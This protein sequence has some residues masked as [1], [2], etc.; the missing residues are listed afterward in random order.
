MTEE[1]GGANVDR[2]RVLV[3]DDEPM[4]LRTCAFALAQAGY[5]VLTSATGEAA[6]E[7]AARERPEVVLLDRHLPDLSGQE[8]LARLRSDAATAD[9]VVVMVSGDYE[10]NHRLEG[11]RGGA[12][13]Y[14]TKPVDVRELLARIKF[15]L[16][17]RER[18]LGQLDTV[19]SSRMRLARSLVSLTDRT[20]ALPDVIAQLAHEFDAELDVAGV[21]LRTRQGGH[22]APPI[23]QRDS[24]GGLDIA[25]SA[26]AALDSPWLERA[27]GLVVVHVPL[28][29]ASETFA[30][31]SVEPRSGA[32]QLLATLVDLAPQLSALLL[33][34]VDAAVSTR[35]DRARVERLLQTEGM[36]P[37][38]Q[39]I[40][41]L[42]DRRVVGYEGLTRFVDG[43]RPDLGFTLAERVG[44]RATLELEAIRRALQA[45]T[46]LPEDVWV[47]VNVSAATLLGADLGPLVAGMSHRLMLEITEHELV[48]DYTA[49]LEAVAGLGEVRVA[50][51]DAGSGYASL[52]HVYELRPDVIKLDRGWVSGIDQD[53]VRQAMIAGLHTFS[54][55]MGATLVGEGIEH[56]EE[57]A[58]LASLGVPWGQG[59][60]FA[61]PDVL[62]HFLVQ[63][64]TR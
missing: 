59:F 13:D 4:M 33:P 63:E 44:M 10:V 7:L 43:T 9:A 11:F 50:V 54:Q 55:A 56:G 37:V 17:S 29:A 45:A 25:M 2:V 49:V 42:S 21:A 35:T 31:L 36:W 28:Q 60:L 41:E 14:L 30:V 8:V 53:P 58:T 48:T 19:M 24:R 47:S 22:L 3:V 39:P 57:A 23:T 20:V 61:R 51:D 52:R 16:S 32:E 46:R 1:R 18:W 34:M 40:V 38:F 62:D 6:L 26:E 64:Q 12:S 5:E 15:Q 27:A